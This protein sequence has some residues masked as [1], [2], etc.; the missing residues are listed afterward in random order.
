MADADKNRVIVVAIVEGGLSVA[1]AARRFG[2]TR[3]WIHR[4]LARYREGGLAA[5]EP[6]SRAPHTP[7]GR[8]SDELR[9]Q[10]VSVR[11]DLGRE[12][13]DAGAES[14]RDRLTRSGLTP[15]SST[16]IYRLLHSHDRVTPEPHKRPRS[17]WTRFEAPSPNSCWQSDMTHWHL[18]GS[19]KIE[20]ITW[21]D[22][23]S[24]FVTH[25][26]AHPIVTAPIVTETFLQA[27]RDHGLPASTL[28]DNGLI[29]TTRFAHGKGG[30]NHFEH[31][32]AALGIVQKNGHPGHP[33]TQGKIERFHQTLKQWLRARPD[34]ADLTSLNE[35]LNHFRST[36]NV[37]RPHRSLNRRTPH[38]AYTAL[39]KDT[40]RIEALG[41]SWRV[42]HDTVDTVGVITLRW[43]GKLRHLAIGRPHRHRRI[44]L[45]VAG[46]DTLVI[47]HETGEIIA[48]H[49]LN[50]DLDYHP[51]K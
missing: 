19:R 43:A 11:D 5:L 48:E 26:S 27:G 10:I 9:E 25:L 40:P 34:A 38:E 13:L 4:L 42:R 29:F 51:K 41:R 50:P 14:I 47:D 2:V 6:Q 16:T 17:S 15:P 12:G 18:S 31:V 1:D 39:A 7:A 35:L 3:Q 33:Q 45:L 44:V 37:D 8:L 20:I 46:N 30:P 23:H 21:L 32:I 36:Y 28:T 49:T 22:D 24:R